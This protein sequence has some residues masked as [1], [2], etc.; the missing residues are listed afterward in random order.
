MV[1]V[2]RKGGELRNII[3]AMILMILQQGASKSAVIFD[4]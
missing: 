4:R 2:M 3:C 1:R